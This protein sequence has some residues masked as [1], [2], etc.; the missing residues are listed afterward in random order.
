MNKGA[1][2][3]KNSEA[4]ECD[5]SFPAEPFAAEER[6]KLRNAEALPHSAAQTAA[7]IADLLRELQILAERSNM[8]FLAYLLDIAQEEAETQK[9]RGF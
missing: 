4:V 5:D 1:K 2:Q 7:Y 9:N 6:V 8:T 3:I